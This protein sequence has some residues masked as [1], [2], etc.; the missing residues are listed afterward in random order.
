VI[1]VDLALAFTTGM[2]ATVNPC[3]F[4][5]LPAYL[6][7][8]IGIEDRN[9]DDPRASVWRALV[10][11]LTVTAGFA[12]TF[13]LVG[14]LVSRVTR[15][16]YDIAPWISLVIGFALA[17]FGIAL[18]AGFEFNVR[19]PRLDKGGRT[20]GLGSMAVFGVSYAVASIGCELP[21]FLAAMSGVF[22]RSLA[23]GIAYFIAFALGF[24]VVLVGLTVAMAMAH[25]SLVHSLRRVLPY[26]SRIAGGLLVVAGAYV[27][28]YG[29]VEIRNTTNDATVT[30]VTDWS[31][32]VG[33]VFSNHPTLSSI[34]LIA[35]VATAVAYLLFGRD[36]QGGENQSRG[37]GQQARGDAAEN[38]DRSA[39]GRPLLDESHGLP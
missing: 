27:A 25:Q 26:V 12:A 20:R 17:G 3:G 22:G 8:F 39:P 9:E 23:S 30:R 21:L 33:D 36:S 7:F 10:V 38:G 18:L 14:L 35:A 13:A 6:S 34:V 19:T 1:D 5:M 29:A 15:S 28:W 11:G 31:Y 4:A 2:V 37:G 16:V 24:A 32:Q